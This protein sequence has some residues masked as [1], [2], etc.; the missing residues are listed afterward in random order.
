MSDEPATPRTAPDLSFVVATERR[1]TIERG[2]DGLRAQT[3]R[4]RV[5]VV[6]VSLSGRSLGIDPAT[7]AGFAGHRLVEQGTRVSLAAGRAAG[8]RAATGRY[9]HVGETHSF[10]RPDWAEHLLA[11]LDGGAAAIVSGLD[12]ENPVGGISWGNFVIDYGPWFVGR[13]AGEISRIPAYNTA[14]ERSTI[15]AVLDDEPEA[16]APGI[17]IAALLR[18]QGHRI[19]FRPDAAIDHVNLAW[20][21]PW[22]RQRYALSR[23]RTAV[24]CRRWPW[25]RRAAYALGSPLIPFVLAARIRQPFLDVRRSR[26]LPATTV[27]ALATSLVVQTFGELAGFLLGAD[28]RLVAE[29]DGYE[30]DRVAYAR[31]EA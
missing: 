15:L 6:L 26:R 27:P 1:E 28:D 13:Q 29:T 20:P 4:D 19:S 31:G 18:R 9:I 5:E 12:N 14:F 11:A 24:R 2:L 16:F 3:A 8:V 30:L 25:P 7:L 17:D 22:L 10:P 21:T 23:T